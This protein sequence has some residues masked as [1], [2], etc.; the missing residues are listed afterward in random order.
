MKQWFLHRAFLCATFISCTAFSAPNLFTRNAAPDPLENK[1][2]SLLANDDIREADSLCTAFDLTRS[3]GP[4]D[5]MKWVR[6]KGTLG[7]YGQAGRLACMATVK[8]RHYGPM[9]QYQLTEVVKDAKIDTVRAVLQTYA[10]CALGEGACDTLAFKQWISGAYDR[11]GLYDEEVNILVSLDSKNHPSAQELLEVARQRFSQRL[12]TYVIRPALLACA[13]STTA[14]QRALCA[15]LLYQSY[16]Q[17]EKNDSAALWLAKVPLSRDSYKAE[18][19]TF[20]QRSRYFAKADSLIKTLPASFMRDTLAIRQMLHEGNVNGATD[21][22]ARAFQAW[23]GDKNNR[24]E[25]M[26]WRIRTLI[27]GGAVGAVAVLLDSINFTPSMNGAEEVLSD[28]YA[29]FIVRSSPAAWK[30]FGSIRYASWVQ[31]PDIALRTLNSP[32]LENCPPGVKDLIIIDGVKVL[33]A[34]KL[35]P[36]A[37][38]VLERTAPVKATVE[39]RYYYAE[40]LLGTGAPELARKELEDLVLKFPGDVFSEKARIVLARLQNKI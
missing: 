22:A 39:R 32:E 35:F 21:A 40:A 12:F 25:G 15:L 20:F 7:Q 11:F 18:A 4:F 30:H 13:R 26:L 14:S 28:R 19:I 34:G 17:A 16:A 6:I 36:E 8:D 10:L 37:R 27:F 9:L 38:A 1:I 33:E 2:S 31:R 23:D 3:M 29:I 24:N 5:L